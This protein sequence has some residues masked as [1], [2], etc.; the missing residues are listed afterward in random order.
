MA[1]ACLSIEAFDEN[2]THR[3]AWAFYHL[4]QVYQLFLNLNPTK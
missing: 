1:D 2:D 4:Y 3:A